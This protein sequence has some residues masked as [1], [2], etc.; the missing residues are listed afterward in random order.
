MYRR[1]WKQ[2][3]SYVLTLDAHMMNHMGVLPGDFIAPILRAGKKI[4]LQKA[5][6]KL[7]LPSRSQRP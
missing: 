1:V 6:T 3:N 7:P 2:G 5:P 4:T